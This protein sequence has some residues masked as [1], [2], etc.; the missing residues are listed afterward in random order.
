MRKK[1]LFLIGAVFCSISGFAQQSDLQY[2]RAYDQRGINV[3]ETGKADTVAFD[4]LKVRI[5]GAFAQQ[6]Q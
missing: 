4:G 2:W 3:F 5:G 6:F 1:I